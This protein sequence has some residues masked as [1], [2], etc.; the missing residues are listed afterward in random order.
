MCGTNFEFSLTRAHD[1]GEKIKAWYI[2]RRFI[3]CVLTEPLMYA[4]THTRTHTDQYCKY[5]ISSGVAIEISSWF[6]TQ[7]EI[8]IGQCGFECGGRRILSQSS[9]RVKNHVAVESSSSSCLL[10]AVVVS[11]WCNFTKSTPSECV[12]NNVTKTH[13]PDCGVPLKRFGFGSGVSGLR[14]RSN[15]CYYVFVPDGFASVCWRGR[16]GLCLEETPKSWW[17]KFT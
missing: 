3:Y 9:L 13:P 7:R 14:L 4:R 12:I 10:D 15:L 6:T 17:M 16:R 2:P 5:R 11:T 8:Y 1:L